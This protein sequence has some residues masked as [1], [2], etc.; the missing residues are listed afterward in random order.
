MVRAMILDPDVA[1]FVSGTRGPRMSVIFDPLVLLI[2]YRYVTLPS[3]LLLVVSYP[4]LRLFLIDQI[5][6]NVN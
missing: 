1:T 6:S 3:S 5:Q 2:R 4:L